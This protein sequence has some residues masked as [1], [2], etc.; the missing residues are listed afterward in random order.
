MDPVTKCLIEVIGGT[1][2]AVMLSYENG[3]HII[4]AAAITSDER[5]IVHCDDL[6]ATTVELAL[7]V[8]VDLEDG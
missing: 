4:E 3:L 6:Y 1:G 5:F 7:Q 2:F 8:G